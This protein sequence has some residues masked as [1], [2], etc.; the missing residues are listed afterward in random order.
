MA[1]LANDTNS[2]VSIM[3]NGSLYVFLKLDSGNV[4][5]LEYV[6][7]ESGETIPS[8]DVPSDVRNTLE[9]H[10]YNFGR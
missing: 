2:E 5:D 4:V 7:T 9:K 8:K 6:V 3:S 10:G 1:H